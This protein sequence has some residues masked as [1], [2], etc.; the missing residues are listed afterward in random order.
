MSLDPSKSDVV[1]EDFASPTTELK[2]FF[3]ETYADYLNHNEADK[4]FPTN[5]VQFLAQSE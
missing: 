5:Q 2:T 1:F 4:K 3:N